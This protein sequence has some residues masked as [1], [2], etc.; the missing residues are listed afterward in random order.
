MLDLLWLACYLAYIYVE[1]NTHDYVI[2][3]FEGVICFMIPTKINAGGLTIAIFCA[4]SALYGAASICT[5]HVLVNISTAIMA[6]YCLIFAMDTWINAYE[7]TWIY[8]NH[9]AIIVFL[10]IV[11]LLSITKRLQVKFNDGFFNI[12]SDSFNDTRYQKC[13]ASLQGRISKAAGKE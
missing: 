3:L 4:L 10:H 2:V 13:V 1:K 5:R 9:E 8:I 6:A 7:K 11:I 12:G